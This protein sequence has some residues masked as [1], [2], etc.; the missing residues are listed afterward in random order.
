MSNIGHNTPTPSWYHALPL[1]PCPS[2]LSL[3][4]TE[5][6]SQDRVAVLIWAFQCQYTMCSRQE[7]RLPH[8]M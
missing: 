4:E 7:Q 6:G 5:K 1:H 3:L 2:P 8:L